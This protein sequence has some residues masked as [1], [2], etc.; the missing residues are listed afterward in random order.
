[1]LIFS[2][3]SN[4]FPFNGIPIFA[5]LQKFNLNSLVST[6]NIFP[7]PQCFANIACITPIGPAPNTSTE[8]F[9]EKEI[10]FQALIQHASGSI[11]DASSKLIVSG[12]L[13]KLSCLIFHSGTRNFSDIP[14]GSK[15]ST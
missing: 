15:H 13:I 9:F 14:Q 7:N 12:I 8:S 11:S 5:S 6:Q 2:L 10:F 4:S 3:I 1:V